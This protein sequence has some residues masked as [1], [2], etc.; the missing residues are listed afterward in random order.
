M[1]KLILFFKISWP[2][3]VWMIAFW[4]VVAGCSP[5]Q[6]LE[7]MQKRHPTLFNRQNDTIKYYDTLKVVVP[8]L[9]MDT[10]ISVNQARKD[11][12]YIY[13]NGIQTKVYIS[14]DDLYLESKTDTDTVI[15]TRILKVPYI[16]YETYNKPRDKL[17]IFAPYFIIAFL[18]VALWYVFKEQKQKAI[19]KNINKKSRQ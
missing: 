12:V 15:V 18:L 11:T 8:G 1:R 3:I 2:F 9:Y 10:V 13:K 14:K 6:R 16:K 7:R 17:R 4:I 19:K 5:I